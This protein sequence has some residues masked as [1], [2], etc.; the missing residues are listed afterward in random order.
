MTIYI[1]QLNFF[2]PFYRDQDLGS[3]NDILEHCIQK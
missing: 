1:L 2:L 3:S